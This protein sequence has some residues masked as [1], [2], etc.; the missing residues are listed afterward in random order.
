MCCSPSASDDSGVCE[1]H[2]PRTDA[3]DDL[4]A[5]GGI[6]QQRQPVA[7]LYLSVI[8]ANVVVIHCV[9]SLPDSGWCEHSAT[10]VTNRGEPMSVTVGSR[11]PSVQ[12]MIFTI[13]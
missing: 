11:A 3:S 6:R 1:Q 7:A 12:L 10:W 5:L 2:R 9:S 13:D 4:C 8:A